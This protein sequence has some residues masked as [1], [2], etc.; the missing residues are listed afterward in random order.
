MVSSKAHRNI[1]KCSVKSISPIP[2]RTTQVNDKTESFQSVRHARFS[3]DAVS[4][5]SNNSNEIASDLLEPSASA[6]SLPSPGTNTAIPEFIGNL[7][8]YLLNTEINDSGKASRLRIANSSCLSRCLLWEGRE[9]RHLCYFCFV[10]A[11]EFLGSSRRR[12]TTGM[13][14][15]SSVQWIQRLAHDHSKALSRSPRVSSPS[16][17][18]SDE[19]HQ[20]RCAIETTKGTEWLSLRRHRWIDAVGLILF[21]LFRHWRNP[22]SCKVILN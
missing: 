1:W 19:S 4:V 2:W 11:V 10:Q 8:N 13:D 20:S 5:S 12:S 22:E 15:L 9:I 7:T 14:H 21:V 17:Q 18:E 3:S 16:E 6:A